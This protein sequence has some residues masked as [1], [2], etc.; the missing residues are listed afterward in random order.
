MNIKDLDRELKNFY[1]FMGGQFVSL[2]GNKLTSFG[3]ILWSYKQGGSVLSMSLL[4]VC[5]LIPEVLLSFIA[6]SISDN[7]DKKRIMLSSNFI[8]AI[9]SISVIFLLFNNDLKIEY[10]YGINFM[11]GVTDAFQDPAYEVTISVIV[12]KDNYMK[13]SG[14]RT[15]CN[16]FTGIFAPIIATSLYAFF[17]LQTIILIDLATFIFVFVTLAFWVK[18]P[19]TI[20]LPKER[21][22]N[23]LYKQCMLGIRYLLDRKDIFS[24]ILFMAFVNLI[25]AIY[26]TNLS[27]MVLSR[28]GNND[29]QLG[30]VSSSISI[31]GLIGS[32]LVARFPHT[33]KKIPLIL[34]IMTFSFLFCNSLLGIGQ[35]YYIWTIA[36]FLGNVLI[37]FLTANVEYIMRTKIPLELQGRVFSARNTLQYTSIPIGNILGGFLVDK[38]FEPYMKK[39]TIVQEFL[40]KIVGTGN[41]SGIAVLFICIGII[42]FL[43]C[44]IFRLNK[45][46]RTLDNE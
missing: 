18:I 38:V 17:G 7:W 13:T 16:S 12:S 34:N 3:L 1:L 2:F 25:A 36:V 41:G 42:G 32:I 20:L 11:L 46:M 28:S 15:L 24:L 23:G 19:P 35:N 43:G 31:A 4:S 6:G 44:C 33:S 21:E 14:L 26:N 10:L 22:K 37:P 9:F 40:T 45:S 27:P 5:Y 29:L 30:I 39:N 8:A